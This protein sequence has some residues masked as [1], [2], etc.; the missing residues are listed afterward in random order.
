MRHREFSTGDNLVFLP[1]RDLVS[2]CPRVTGGIVYGG[3]R[4]GPSIAGA[5]LSTP[6]KVAL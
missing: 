1:L 4:L 2:D 5:P 3:A 6:L